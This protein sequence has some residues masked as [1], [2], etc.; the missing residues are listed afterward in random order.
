MAANHLVGDG[1]DHAVEVEPAVLRGER[2]LE[3]HLEE[4]VTELVAE[5]LGRT[6]V[7]GLDDLVGLFDHV[8]AQG[9]QGL[10]AI[11]GAA[12]GRE[13]GR[14][15]LGQLGE[16]VPHTFVTHRRAIARPHRSVSLRPSTLVVCG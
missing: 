2:R 12:L 8:S 4:Q 7:D 11:P 14:H 13:Q 9:L 10:R 1:S 16:A 6:R 3:H 5:R 15:Q